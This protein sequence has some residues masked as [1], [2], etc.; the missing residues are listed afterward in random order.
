MQVYRIENKD[1]KLGPYDMGLCSLCPFDWDRRNQ[2]APLE[3]GIED[4]SSKHIFGFKSLLQLDDWFDYQTRAWFEE[5]GSFITIYDV[6][7]EHVVKGEKQ[8]AFVAK[9]A[10]LKGRLQ[11]YAQPTIH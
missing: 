5:R 6:P 11:L 2:P 10:T 1:T 8:V 7:D 3:D 4:F 9:K